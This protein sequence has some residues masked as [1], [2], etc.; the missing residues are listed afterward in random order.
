LEETVKVSRRA[1]DVSL[2]TFAVGYEPFFMCLLLPGYCGV[3][4]LSGE[5]HGGPQAEYM[6]SYH[7]DIYKSAGAACSFRRFL[8]L[9]I[10]FSLSQPISR[11]QSWG[12]PSNLQAEV[13][14]L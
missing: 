4:L 8:S 11:I 9:F 5:E 7:L 14:N 12:R 13:G 2:S 10:C 6:G 3:V 1:R